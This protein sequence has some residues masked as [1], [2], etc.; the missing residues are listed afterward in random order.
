M[1]SLAALTASMLLACGSP[2]DRGAETR[3]VVADAICARLADA[4]ELRV[5]AHEAALPRLHAWAGPRISSTGRARTLISRR[6][7]R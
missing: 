4:M 5:H 7:S 1:K 2:G 6:G 3:A